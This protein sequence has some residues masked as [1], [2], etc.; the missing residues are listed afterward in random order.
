MLNMRLVQNGLMS[1]ISQMGSNNRLEY[2]EY[3]VAGTGIPL[4]HPSRSLVGHSAEHGISAATPQTPAV[5]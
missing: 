3:S 4:F 2:S 5:Y 1:G